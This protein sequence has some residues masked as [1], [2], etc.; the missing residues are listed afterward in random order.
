[1]DLGPMDATQCS[2]IHSSALA[3]LAWSHAGKDLDRDNGDEGGTACWT[4][5]TGMLTA[6]YSTLQPPGLTVGQTAYHTD[7]KTGP[8]GF[9]TCQNDTACQCRNKICTHEIGTVLVLPAKVLPAQGQGLDPASWSLSF[10]KSFEEHTQGQAGRSPPC[11]DHSLYRGLLREFGGASFP[12]AGE[13]G[14]PEAEQHS[15]E[16]FYGSFL[17][18]NQRLV[19]ARGVW[20]LG[21]L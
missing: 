4:E 10:S 20:L 6:P 8:E 12:L 13:S 17:R 21:S 14:I 1:M 11:R 7:R 5:R 3:R 15:A 16:M 18:K 19:T 2:C 9:G